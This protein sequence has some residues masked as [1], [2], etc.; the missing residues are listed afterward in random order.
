MDR[1]IV[2]P[3]IPLAAS[4]ARNTAAFATSAS[5]ESRFVWVLPTRASWNRSQVLPDASA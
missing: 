1:S 4:D 3:V 2:V 5:V